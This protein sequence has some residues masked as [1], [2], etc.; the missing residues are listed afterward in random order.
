M[1]SENKRV[2]FDIEIGGNK[3]GRIVMELF[4]DKTPKTAE[5]FRALCTGEKGIGKNGKPLSYKGSGFHRVIKQFMIQGGDFTAGNGTG[6]ESIYGEKFDDE[7]FIAKHT[8]AGLLSM[9]NS[10]PGTNGSQFFITTISTPHL[11]NKHVVF[12]KVIKGMSVVREIESQPT[13]ANDKP[14]KDCIIM[15]CG[16]LKEGEDDG[17]PEKTGDD[18]WEDY[19]QDDNVEGN[20]A[21]LKVGE[22][23][24]NIGNDYFKQ[25]KSLEAIAKYN[26]ALRYLDCCSNIDGLKNVQTICYNNMSQCYLKEKKGSNA[27]VA[28]KKALELSPNDIKALFR[29]AKALS[30]MEEYDEAI[31]DFQ[32]IIE[33]DSENKDAKLELERIKKLQ[34]AKDLKSAKA[35]SKLFS[36]DD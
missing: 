5:N 1:T 33:T 10:G 20:E 17:V 15:D 25:G 26:K 18:K 28:A 31:K 3:V 9:A 35:Y 19:P 24:K 29:K 32:K 36:D 23:I 16:E 6:G 14:I 2:Y 27:L 22:A 21:N 4:F 13:G 7:N 11:D 34:K 30:L 12:G 8:K